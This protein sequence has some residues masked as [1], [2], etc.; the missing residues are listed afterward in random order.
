MSTANRIYEKL[1]ANAPELPAPRRRVLPVLFGLV[2]LAPLAYWGILPVFLQVIDDDTGFMKQEIA[3]STDTPS[4]GGA[5][6]TGAMPGEGAR[7]TGVVPGSVQITIALIRREVDQYGWTANDPFFMPTYG[8][9]N[10]PNFQKGIVLGLYR[11]SL[12]LAD[13]LGRTRGS[14]QVDADLDKAAGLLKYSGDVWV[15]DPSTSMLPTASSEKQYRSAMRSLEAYAERLKNGEAVF[16]R[17]S[18]NLLGTLDRMAADLGSASAEIFALAHEPGYLPFDS[19][20]DDLF[21]RNKGR[22]Y[23]YYLLLREMEHDFSNVIQDR[24]LG[25]AWAGMLDSLRI[26]ATLDP[27]VVTVG[28]PDGMMA[29][30]HLGTQGFYLLRART[31]MKEITNILLK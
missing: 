6:D 22:L 4:D 26:A 14:S 19:E 12:E 31:Q 3:A 1:K 18:D 23:A 2:L 20:A 10:M 17:R 9:D 13:Q 29:P 25:T 27:L 28:S 5:T 7:L 24:D 16:E 11:F 21:Y 8:L 30:N 15:L